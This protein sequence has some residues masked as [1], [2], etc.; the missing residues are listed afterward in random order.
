MKA[1]KEIVKIAKEKCHYDNTECAIFVDAFVKG[2]EHGYKDAK[3]ESVD[4]S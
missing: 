2:Y 1:R 3:E 4:K